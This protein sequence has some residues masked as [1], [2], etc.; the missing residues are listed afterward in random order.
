MVLPPGK[1]E[2]VNQASVPPVTKVKPPFCI[3]GRSPLRSSSFLRFIIHIIGEDVEERASPEPVSHAHALRN[4]HGCL[5]KCFRVT[6]IQF[7][8]LER[9]SFM[10]EYCRADCVPSPSPCVFPSPECRK[11]ASFFFPGCRVLTKLLI[12]KPSVSN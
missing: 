11:Y 5:A 3:G 2:L 9:W 1:S 10:A 7:L 8:L 12:L 6:K 4:F